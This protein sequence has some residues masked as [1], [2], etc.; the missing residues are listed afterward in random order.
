MTQP[1]QPERR[2]AFRIT[3]QAL[4]DITLLE[5]QFP[6]EQLDQLLPRSDGFQLLSELQQIDHQ[7]QHQLFKLADNSPALAAA[8]RLLNK[9]I[10]RLALH[11]SDSTTVSEPQPVTLSTTGLSLSRSEP[12]TTD[13]YCAIRLRLLPGGYAVQTLAQVIYSQLQQ[14]NSYRIGLLFIDPDESGQDLIAG[15]ILQQQ[16]LIRRTERQQQLDNELPK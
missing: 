15:H 5:Q 10:E 2:Q 11:A 9:K 14:D 4:I 3:D 8:L 1:H 6:S 13:T 12:I 7:L 16:A